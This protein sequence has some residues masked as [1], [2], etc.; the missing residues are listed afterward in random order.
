MDKDVVERFGDGNLRFITFDKGICNKCKHINENGVTCKAFPKGIPE[1]IL[2]G[3]H[4]HRK[5]YPNDK[6]IRFEP[7]TE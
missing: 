4:D 3:D 5:P 2:R 7:I 6:G 1:E